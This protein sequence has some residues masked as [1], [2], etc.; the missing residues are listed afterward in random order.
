MKNIVIMLLFSSVFFGQTQNL[1]NVEKYERVYIEVGAFNP[2]G[3]LK[4]K[5]KLSP[6]LG[7]WFKTKL[8]AD[9][10]IDVGFNIN[11]FKANEKFAYQKSDS[12]FISQAEGVS[13]MIGLRYN[14]NYKLSKNISIDWFPSF[15]YGFLS[16]KPQV[17]ATNLIAKETMNRQFLSTFHLGQ[18]IRFNVDNIGFQVQYQYVPYHIFYK[19]LDKNFGAQGLT[20]GIVYRQ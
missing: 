12:I 13:G 20:F 1:E 6:N 4:D 15:G 14:L 9:E 16:H 11:Y 2:I 10:S 18:G 5:V 17:Q 3:T 7:F 19:H 8:R